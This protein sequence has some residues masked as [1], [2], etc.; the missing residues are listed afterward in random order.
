MRLIFFIGLGL[1]ITGCSS[2]PSSLITSTS[3]LPPGIRGTIPAS[4]SNCQVNLLGLIPIT[5]SADS[6]DALDEAKEEADVDVLTDVTVDHGGVYLILFS[7]DCV[8]V[9]GKGVPREILKGFEI[10][11]ES[12]RN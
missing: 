10:T 3:P 8:R 7:T 2:R 5:G 4:G 9:R 1:L 12:F 11:E 6:Q